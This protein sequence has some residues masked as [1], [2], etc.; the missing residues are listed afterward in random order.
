MKRFKRKRLIEE[1]E[2]NVQCLRGMEKGISLA[3]LIIEEVYKAQPHVLG[4]FI[5]TCFSAWDPQK[6]S[7]SSGLRKKHNTTHKHSSY[8]N[9]LGENGSQVLQ[10]AALQRHSL[11]PYGA[12]VLH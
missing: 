11:E 9:T 2:R 4:W 6:D 12:E 10:A 7:Q 3:L 5:P 1:L 8:S